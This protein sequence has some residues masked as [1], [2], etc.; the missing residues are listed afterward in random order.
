MLPLPKGKIKGEIGNKSMVT[1][2]IYDLPNLLKVPNLLME[3]LSLLPN[4]STVF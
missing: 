3:E 4:N 1:F 2:R